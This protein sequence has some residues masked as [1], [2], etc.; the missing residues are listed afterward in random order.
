M[1]AQRAT[2]RRLPAPAL[3][4]A[5]LV[6]AALPLVPRPA[7]GVASVLYVGGAGCSDTG[8]GTAETPFC[9][10]SA[11]AGVAVAGQSVEVAGGTYPETVA[12]AASGAA[13]APITFRAAPGADV[14][15]SGETYGFRLQGV[16]WVTVSGF[17]VSDTTS[18]GI[19]LN[20]ASHIVIS[21]NTVRRAGLRVQGLNAPGVYVK[22]TVDSTLSGNVTVDNSA[23]GIYLTGS[24]T[25]V[26]VTGNESMR[27]A[28]GWQRNANGI[29]VR[30]AGNRIIGNRTHDN[31]DSGIQMYPGGNN[32]LVAGN[33]SSDN[34][35]FTA[36]SLANCT[37]P[38]TGDTSGCFTG[39][40]GIDNLKVTGNVLVGNTV[41]GNTT[42][43]MNLEGLTA[44]APSGAV[45]AN[46]V[47][48]DNAVN[49]PDGA[50]GTTTCPA[51]KGNLRVD[52]T[53]GTG[54]VA[55]HDVLWT[56]LA[57]GYLAVWGNGMYRNLTDFRSASGQEGAG[58]QAEPR[59]AD[60][61]AADFHL[62]G[63]SP[64][65]DMADSGA[66]GEQATDIEGRARAD[67][68][69]TPDTGVGPRS[70]DDAGAY[71]YPPV[72][73]APVLSAT[74]GSQEVTL[75]W[76]TPPSGGSALTRYTV[77]RGTSPSG[78]TALARVGPDA[79]TYED[80]GVSG[81]TTYYYQL[82]ASNSDGESPPSAM[83]TATPTGPPVAPSAPVAT[84]T[85]GQG[86]VTL[87][88]APPD[89]HGSPLTG[90]TVYR[91]TSPG[92]EVALTTLGPDATGYTDMGLTN[93]TRYYYRVTATNGVGESPLSDEVPATPTSI[94][95]VG[96][97]A[98]PLTSGV[99]SASLTLP[100][101]IATGDLL[102]AW[103]GFTNAASNIAGLNGWSQFT[104]S[105]QV[106]G[107]THTTAAYWKIAGPGEANPTVTWSTTSKGVFAAAAYR[108]VD[109]TAPIAASA[110]LPCDTKS[111]ATVR[112]PVVVTPRSD[113]W[114]VSL[115]LS[116]TSVTASRAV[117]WS[118]DP[119]LAER[120]DANNGA[121][122][123]SP[124]VGV[125][126]ADSAG[127]VASGSHSYVATPSSTE[128]H[129][130]SALLYLNEIPGPS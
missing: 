123:S 73:G 32:T 81:W 111:A 11:A 54:T 91:T 114:A 104:W 46:N 36:T 17:T 34:M 72:P 120:V 125:E 31:E 24:S 107:T 92:A 13:G 43:G 5:C 12:P 4:V 89:S 70:Y 130:S 20:G 79:T 80:T 113:T 42:A 115:A 84:A 65:I 116:R 44:G 87:A 71:E 16:S 78:V 76:A 66:P 99:T 23:S 33:V 83:V 129:H 29:D 106:D 3:A 112:T 26:L 28:F 64:A 108:G 53:S 59:F 77:Y 127:P 128:A 110:G 121:A 105:P 30:A 48:V 14:T 58:V 10:I 94:A 15:V 74:G 50:G 2:R 62:R 61:A 85:S 47:S 57:G 126:I 55:N 96:T 18:N 37:H 27:N 119:S 88:W 9:T 56:S 35:G 122:G 1:P 19:Y 51:T 38:T 63:G 25:R 21:G 7:L 103:L 69:S 67:D 100:P 82:T 86:A 8:A 45:F 39:D 6:A 49:C 117:T 40:H 93:G 52:A 109:T 68:V 95:I 22:D 60:A 90:Y 118:A 41:F 98:R 101:G 102:I 75:S 97:S 124:W